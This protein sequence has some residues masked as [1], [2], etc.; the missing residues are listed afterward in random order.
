MLSKRGM[1]I[2]VTVSAGSCG[3]HLQ[4]QGEGSSGVLKA[5]RVSLHLLSCYMAA[6]VQATESER[7]CP[8]NVSLSKT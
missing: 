8:A 2:S 3:P 7:V 1:Y 4:S 5:N 6:R